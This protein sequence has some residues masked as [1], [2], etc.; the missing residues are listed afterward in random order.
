MKRIIWHWTAGA[1]GVINM[2]ADA[3]HF[4]INP[5][6]SYVAGLDRPEDNIPPLRPGAYAAHTLNLNSHSIGIAI[7]A[8]AGAQERPFKAGQHPITSSQVEALCQLTAKLCMKYGIPV[9]RQ[10]TLSHAEVQPT[11]GVQ[12][13]N[14]W[15]IKWLPDMAAPGNPVAVGDKL[16][17]R[18]S[19]IIASR[20]VREKVEPAPVPSSASPLQIRK[21]LRQMG[22]KAAIDT[23]IAGQDEEVQEAWE[24]AVQID[25]DNAL[26][27]AAAAQL[28]KTEADIDDLFRLAVTL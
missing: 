18:V 3:Y 1:Y 25:R 10:T 7:D 26:I 16:R 20:E 19:A 22:L 24:Y 5:D 9:S 4:I 27:A 12:Q 6:G 14:K 21:A 2:E 13:R 28:N 15:D 17:A 11:L 8:M 23:F